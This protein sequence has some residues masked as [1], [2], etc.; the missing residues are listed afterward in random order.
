MNS[1]P[2]DVGCSAIASTRPASICVPEFQNP[3]PKN[4]LGPIASQFPLTAFTADDMPA[5]PRPII[6]ARRASAIASQF[7]CV[8]GQAR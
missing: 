2:G 3:T 8:S 1:V 5:N 7:T 6:R 4:P